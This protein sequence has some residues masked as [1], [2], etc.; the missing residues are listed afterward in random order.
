M[1]IIKSVVETE[2]EI[3]SR[4]RAARIA[5]RLTQS[6]LAVQAGVSVV[7]V[8]RLEQARGTRLASLIRVLKVLD[9]DRALIPRVPSVSPLQ[10][11]R[12]ESLRPPSR[13]RKAKA[14]TP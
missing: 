13:V 3:G 12:R 7:V 1:E 11:S 9:M 5:S 4:V 2:Q 8:K 10:V 14:G 6:D